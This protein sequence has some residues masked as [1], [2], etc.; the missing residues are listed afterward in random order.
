[1]PEILERTGERSAERR[2]RIVALLGEAPRPL[3]G[4][5]LAQR[6]NV[7]RQVVVQDIAVLRASGAAILATP[8]GY[9]LASRL[10]SAAHRIV[11]ACRHT[12]EQVEDELLAMVDCRV[13][14]VDV[15]VE[16]PLYGELRAPLWLRT[17]ADVADFVRQL[18][19]AGASLLSSLT[20]GVHLHTLEAGEPAALAAA[21]AALAARGYLLDE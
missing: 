1:M 19:Q 15:I 9:L 20:G 7:T 3:T 17:P 4:T 16:H 8:Q 18:N 14:V 5:E 2:R 12:R 13:T 21:R 10:R 11:V 6:L